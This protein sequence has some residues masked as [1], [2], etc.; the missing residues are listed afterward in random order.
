MKT[1]NQ[2]EGFT[3]VEL[4]VVVAII[5]ILSAVA[6]PNFQRYQA[7]SKASEARIQLSSIYTAEIAFAGDYDNFASCLGEMGFDPGAPPA[8]RYYT[9]GF[10][11]DAAVADNVNG[12]TCTQS[13]DRIFVA[14]KVVGGATSDATHLTAAAIPATGDTF[15]AQAAGVVSADFTGSGVSDLWQIDELKDLQQIRVGY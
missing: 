10:A 4:M 2:Q 6:I 7:K 15:D 3:L 13:T 14:G 9:V 1:L 11:N 12:S 5:G 8:S